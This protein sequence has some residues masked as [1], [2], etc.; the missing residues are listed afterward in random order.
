MKDASLLTS[1]APLCCPVTL[2]STYGSTPVC[3]PSRGGR[4]PRTGCLPWH[5]VTIC[6]PRLPPDPPALQHL[7]P[8]PSSLFFSSTSFFRNPSLPST[9]L[10]S[11]PLP[12]PPSATLPSL[13]PP[14]SSH[15]LAR[16]NADWPLHPQRA[17]EEQLPGWKL[18]VGVASPPLPP[19]P[20]R[21]PRDLRSP[22]LNPSQRA[23]LACRRREGEL[24]SL[25]Q[26][27]QRA[28]QCC[29]NQQKDSESPVLTP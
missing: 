22:T 24:C 1:P 29:I 15:I 11:H 23:C 14:S 8:Q 2:D 21:L 16:R 7:C 27:G 13:T 12:S 10:L 25:P 6:P 18:Q 3:C 9:T 26:K 20:V 5:C 4:R 19:F 28:V 17:H